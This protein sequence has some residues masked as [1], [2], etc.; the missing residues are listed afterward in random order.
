M[1]VKIFV[2][3]WRLAAL[4][5]LAVAPLLACAASPHAA[6]FDKPVPDSVLAHHRGG[7]A[8]TFNT[9]NLDAKLFDN[10]ASYNLTGSN[11]ITGHAF[12]GSSGVPT[13]IQNS[14]NN[15]I[16]QNATILNVTVR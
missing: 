9:Q 12:A 11:R 15:V 8:V 2:F 1:T 16:I 4:S 13:V 10:Q 7:H 3:A 6:T 5:L 14:G